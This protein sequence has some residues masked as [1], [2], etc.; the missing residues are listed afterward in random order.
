MG[1]SKRSKYQFL[2]TA[3]LVL[4]LGMVMAYAGSA[5]AAPQY[6][7]NCNSCHT[8]PPRDSATTKKDPSNGAVPGNHQTHANTAVI[9]CAKCHGT[10]VISYDNSHRN[11]K[12]EFI[13][14]LGYGRKPLDPAFMNQTSV[15]PS[16][17]ATC[18][19]AACHSD[20]KNI[21]RATPAWS[22]T[23]AANCDT[24]HDSK[25]STNSHT[26]HIS[27]VSGYNI[28]C[29]QCHTDHVNDAKPF[30]HA[31][32]AGRKIDVHFTTAPNVGGTFA[33]NQC[34]NLYCHS[35]GQAGSAKITAVPTWG[36]TD[37]TCVSCHGN[38]TSN[39]LSGKHA[40]HVNNAAVI[41]TNF[42]CVVCH[43]TT[44]SDNSTISSTTNHVNGSIQVAGA[45]VGTAVAGTCAT[46]SCHSDGKGNA[47]TVTWTQ[48]ATLDCK[49]C[50]GSAT[51]PAF[52]S[53]AG[54]PNYVN[55]GVDQT[56]ANS[57]NKHVK[58][59]ADCQNCH[60]STTV[61]GVSIKAGSLKHADGFINMSAGNGKS[62]TIA[63]KNCSNISCHS[64]N[65]I[66][67]NVPAAKWGATL[68]CNGCHADASTLSTGS[69]TKHLAK[70]GISCAD[71]HSATASSNTVL[72]SGT[73]THVNG[74]VTVG[75]GII[76]FD[77]TA[78][79]CTT[80]CHNGASPTWGN[81][82]GTVV[83]GTC[84]SVG[85]NFSSNFV[86]YNADDP[87][88][89]NVHF[90]GTYGPN[91][92][93]GVTANGCASCH[94]FTDVNASN[95]DNL[96]INLDGTKVTGI[97]N[98]SLTLA[99][100]NSGLTAKCDTCHT[101]ATVWK[102]SASVGG[103]RLD[104]ETCHN[105]AAP[106]IIG[107]KTA[108]TKP[109]FA[110]NG[111]GK[112]SAAQTCVSCHDNNSAHIG[113]NG[114]K[115]LKTALT[116]STNAE[117][118]TCHNDASIIVNKPLMLNMK[119]HRASGVGSKCSDCHNAHGTTNIMM[120]NTTI[121]GK[122]ISLPDTQSFV[123]GGGTGVCQACHTN[124]AAGPSTSHFNNTGTQTAHVASTSNCLDCH[125]HNPTSGGLAFTPNGGCDACHGYPPA[126][127]NVSVVFG[128][129]GQWSSARFEDYSGGGGAHL[130]AG[131]IPATAKQSDG[132]ANCISC[133]SGGQATHA[134]VLPLRDNVANVKVLV[135]PTLRFSNDFQATYTSAK[136]VSGGANKTG[137]CFNVSCHFQ[138][139]QKWSTER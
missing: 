119:A 121:N 90:G 117:C 40:S 61:D 126:P 55:A 10:G 22:S 44:V 88:L 30:Q 32:S 111:H 136:L 133:H 85:P 46:S 36:A 9:S 56:L 51:T 87:A 100:G 16:P 45:R 131:H 33:L 21:Y 39:T 75:S 107:G 38:A 4:S 41:G 71:C 24:C 99:K 2:K 106:S 92:T 52:T 47:K 37:V 1:V 43:S 122:T 7:L 42:G 18:S 120:V 93:I 96:A 69:H 23:V 12:I 3:M 29:N 130:V 19:T 95:H 129:Q 13:D 102:S 110:T 105:T 17:L 84:H 66:V 109:L 67:A 134:R 114:T 70:S 123:N 14:G 15:P 65:G 83:C 116:A 62:F 26:K 78:K 54:E 34:S 59:A 124:P 31:T 115:R 63:T 74:L 57:H 20:G 6:A 103:A 50:H 98:G 60:A 80:V 108:A 81:P 137:S 112:T 91:I 94:A 53:V 25:P 28:S 135:D 5:Q 139:T 27:N 82:G 118:N 79:N 58:L 125:L 76:T 138:T 97:T 68:G 35:N 104:C 113:Q 132:W 73:T 86:Q 49:G 77:P 64:G 89:H 8:M 11:K 48:A 72:A 101:Q 128:K 127:R